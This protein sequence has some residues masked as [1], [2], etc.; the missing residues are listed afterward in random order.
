MLQLLQ[1]AP[2][3]ELPMLIH[4]VLN[5]KFITRLR[6]FVV[7]SEHALPTQVIPLNHAWVILE[8]FLFN[9]SSLCLLHIFHIYL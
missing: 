9:I 7:Y 4:C 2:A 1:S 8:S 6:L 3:L 5:L